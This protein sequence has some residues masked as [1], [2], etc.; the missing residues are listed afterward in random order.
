V[1]KP[2]KVVL[3]GSGLL[4]PLHAG[5]IHR[6]QE[7]HDIQAIAGVSGGAIIGS[8]FASGL[9]SDQIREIVLETAPGDNLALLDLS[10]FPP[11][12]WG[13]LKG[14]KFL[15]VFRKH[16]PPTF[17]ET[18]I[19]LTVG[20]VNIDQRRS[21]LF[22]SEGTPN[23]EPALAVRA[24]MG[25]PFAFAPVKIDGERYIDGGVAA[26]FP[27][28]VFGTGEN[29]LGVKIVNEIPPEDTPLKSLLDYGFAVIGTMMSAIDKEH[30]EDALFARFIRV[31]T[32]QSSSNLFMTRANA[33]TMF[34][35]GY[36]A[37]SEW[38]DKYG[39]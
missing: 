1:K 9:S 27:L 30:I 38:L 37:A 2:I 11:A 13:L 21:V 23:A 36:V 4:Y 26:S 31:S 35:E 16:L 14:N 39:H 19:P 20:T 8:L 18:E 32:S 33:E 25:F 12:S 34:N 6:I 7:D 22:S 5:A 3:S 17:A 15:E 29:V 24:S 10:W 28:D